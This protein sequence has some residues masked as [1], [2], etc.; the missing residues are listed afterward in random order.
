[1]KEEENKPKSKIR[2]VMVYLV[3][4]FLAAFLLLLLSFFMQQRNHQAILDLGSDLKN[5]QLV[6]D[7]E[8]QVKAL[9]EE[10]TNLEETVAG[11]EKELTALDWLRRI[12]AAQT[13]EEAKAL[14]E[15]FEETGLNKELPNSPLT[16]N[17]ESPADV[18]R[19]IYA[20][21]Y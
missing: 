19:D 21:L 20:A 12:Q 15:T 7:L 9:E 3:I 16:E 17:A 14:I 18:Y 10:K 8:K 11:Q 5:T 2:S 6:T 1:L 13:E 4:L